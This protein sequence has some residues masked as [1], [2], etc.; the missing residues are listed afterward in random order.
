MASHAFILIRNANSSSRYKKFL[1]KHFILSISLV[2]K[3]MI[4]I[5]HFNK[6]LCISFR[7]QWF[8]TPW[9]ETG[10]TIIIYVSLIINIFSLSVYNYNDDELYLKLLYT[11]CIRIW[12]ILWPHTCFY[13][14]VTQTAEVK[15]NLPK[16]LRLSSS[17]SCE[18]SRIVT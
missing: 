13:S 7:F 8:K 1:F 5:F 14:S 15:G 10:I 16:G 2:V 18:G 12:Q 3:Y 17:G 6:E 11:W 9:P 4:I